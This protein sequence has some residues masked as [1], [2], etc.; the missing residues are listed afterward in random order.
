[1]QIKLIIDRFDQAGP[2]K[3]Q[4]YEIEAPKDATLLEALRRLQ[5]DVDGTLAMEGSCRTGLCGGCTMRANGKSLHACRTPIA[6]LAQSGTVQV[7][8]LR[9]IPVRKDLVCD[10]E[11]F[12][13]GKIK[14]VRPW[15]EPGERSAAGERLIADERLSVVRKAMN[16]TMCGLCDEGC[17]VIAVDRSFWGPAALTKAYRVAFDPRDSATKEHLAHYQQ[18]RG[19]WDCTHCF[20]ASSHCPKNINPTDRIFDLRD[21]AIKL[22]IADPAAA[23]HHASFAA[24]VKASGWLDEGRLAVESEGFTNIPG[25]LRLMPTALR[26]LRKG[27]APLP[28]KHPKRPGADRIKRIIKKA[29]EK[30]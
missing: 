12:L 17:T 21:K 15:I 26:A 13:F 29:E 28:Y 24:S 23:R 5:E 11:T 9:H 20:E 30:R 14:A 16:C 7:G 27:K 8:P 6:S 25:L 3:A 2:G 10:T 4:Q 19:L 18:R 1:M 22:G